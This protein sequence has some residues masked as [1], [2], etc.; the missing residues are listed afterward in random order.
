MERLDIDHLG[1]FVSE[2]DSFGMLEEIKVYRLIVSSTDCEGEVELLTS[3]VFM[4]DTIS[5]LL[6]REFRAYPFESI[7]PESSDTVI[8]G[9]ECFFY[10][11]IEVSVS[12]EETSFCV[13]VAKLWVFI[14][15]A[16][17][18]NSIWERGIGANGAESFSEGNSF[19]D[20]VC[21]LL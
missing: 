14:E 13:L 15:P 9:G 6:G 7:N 12:L 20:V 21:N 5:V 19:T 1:F 10:Y 18:C 3:G 8:M 17:D 4:F 16:V 11:L 2:R